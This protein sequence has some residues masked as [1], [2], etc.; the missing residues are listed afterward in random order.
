[1]RMLIRIEVKIQELKR[2]KMEPWRAVH[3]NN[4]GPE[5]QNWALDGL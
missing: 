5:A 4:E 3:T 1:M 2:L